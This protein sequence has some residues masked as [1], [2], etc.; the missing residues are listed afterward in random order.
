[1]QIEGCPKRYI[2]REITEA[3]NVASLCGNGTL[4]IAGGLMDQSAWF[5]SMWQTLESDTAKIE[6]DQWRRKYGG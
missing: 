3:V 6:A 1:M 2:G 5:V 4:P